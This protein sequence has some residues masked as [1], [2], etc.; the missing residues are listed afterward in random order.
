MTTENVQVLDPNTV[1]VGDVIAIPYYYFGEYSHE[2]L[3]YVESF[4]FALGVFLSDDARVAGNFTPLCELYKPSENS[5]QEYI[6]NYGEYISNKIPNWR[7]VSK[8]P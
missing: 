1:S 5:K 6:S 2:E 7:I 8:R 4:R 3:H